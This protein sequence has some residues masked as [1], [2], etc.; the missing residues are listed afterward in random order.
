M[1]LTARGPQPRSTNVV[2]IWIHM[3]T[4]KDKAMLLLHFLNPNRFHHQVSKIWL[5]ITH[6]PVSNMM[7]ATQGIMIHSVKS[8]TNSTDISREG[9]SD[10]QEKATQSN[11]RLKWAQIK[12]A[13]TPWCTGQCCH[14]LPHEQI[15]T[16]TLCYTISQVHLHPRIG[17]IS[18]SH[19][20]SNRTEVNAVPVTSVHVHDIREW[21]GL[22]RWNWLQRIQE[23]HSE[24][25]PGPSGPLWDRPMTCI[26]IAN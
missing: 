1:A 8:P 23:F 9:R 3:E 10:L 26:P 5:G 14:Q 20:R 6:P 7:I 12:Q 24:M 19:V 16:H 17:F 2:H 13:V 18:L 22:R 4:K 21:L 25:S 11:S 15:S